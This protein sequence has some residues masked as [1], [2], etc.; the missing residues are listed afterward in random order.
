MT[1][2]TEAQA[3]ELATRIRSCMILPVIRGAS[4]GMIST[5]VDTLKEAGLDAVELTMTTP[6]ALDEIARLRSA[7]GDDLLLGMGSV[8][9][10]ADAHRA[11]DHGAHFVVSP[12]QLPTPTQDE[13]AVAVPCIP[14]ALTPSE[15]HAAAAD[16][17]PLVKLFPASVG[18]P[19]YLR[20][21][22]A[23][24]PQLSVMP[25]GGVS[26]DSVADWR[27]AGATVVS[28]GSSLLGDVLEGGDPRAL[29]ER[30]RA[31]R[32]QWEMAFE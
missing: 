15:L 32:D 26:V 9:T 19:Q 17:V 16:D 22:L 25:S 27:R 8:L 23:P 20:E 30:V 7:W 28:L 13:A 2:A 29:S 11:A 31:A 14:A 5:V 3:S 12:I 6:G 4:S 1:A 24:M 18:G 10:R 21:V